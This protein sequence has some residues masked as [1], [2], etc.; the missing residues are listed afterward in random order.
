MVVGSGKSK[1]LQTSGTV[2]G[3][4]PLY[5]ILVPAPKRPLVANPD[6]E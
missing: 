1:H 3:Y 5:E 2:P 4:A 6:L